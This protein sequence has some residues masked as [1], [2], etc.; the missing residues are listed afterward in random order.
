M[1]GAARLCEGIAGVCEVAGAR[2]GVAMVWGHSCL[3]CEVVRV[4]SGV[5]RTLGESVNHL[6]QTPRP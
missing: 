6:Q 5:T 1:R 2:E 3:Y 4:W